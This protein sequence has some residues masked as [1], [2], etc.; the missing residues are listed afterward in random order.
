[1][2]KK[3]ILTILFLTG[4]IGI[5][6]GQTTE[7]EFWT[8]SRIELSGTFDALN[9]S[10]G[11]MAKGKKELFNTRKFRGFAGFALQY[12]YQNETDK[13]L[14]QGLIGYNN[15]FGIYAVFDLEHAYFKSKKFFTGLEPFI[16]VTVLNSNGTLNLPDYEI[17]EQYTNTYTYLNYG[18][19]SKIGYKFGGFQPNIFFVVPLKGL[20]DKGRNRVGGMDSRILVGACVSYTLKS[21]R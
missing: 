21:T 2:Y 5:T 6:K 19:T 8:N 14:N 16:G 13:A 12:S 15:D 1:M 10:V 7:Q 4:L 3:H 20:F 18:V 11:F 17:S 9:H